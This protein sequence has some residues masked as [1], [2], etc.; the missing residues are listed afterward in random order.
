MHCME[1]MDRGDSFTCS[2]RIDLWIFAKFFSTFC[3][4]LSLARRR[5]AFRTGSF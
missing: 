4:Y 5:P 2:D 3:R 1:S